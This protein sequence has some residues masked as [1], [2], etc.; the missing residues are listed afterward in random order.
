MRLTHSAG[1]GES[2]SE[3]DNTSSALSLEALD[4]FLRRLSLRG[5]GDL[6]VVGPS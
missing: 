2:H 5:L 3:S 4:Q 6:G 1:D